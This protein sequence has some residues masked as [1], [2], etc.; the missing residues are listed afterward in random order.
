MK[1]EDINRIIASYIRGSTDVDYT[2]DTLSM[3]YAISKLTTKGEVLFVAQLESVFLRDNP[4]WD[5]PYLLIGI[6]A[7]P[8]QLAEAFVKAIGQ[9]EG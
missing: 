9:Y 7:H 3:R 6:K 8:W 2:N 4:L 5:G 1:A